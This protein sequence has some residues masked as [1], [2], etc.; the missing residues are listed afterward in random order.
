[1][2]MSDEARKARNEYLREWRKANAEKVK[3]HQQQY[4]ERK[5]AAESQTD[6]SAASR[7]E[8]QKT[9][10]Q[11]RLRGETIDLS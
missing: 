9:A 5:A 4:W 3:K 8:K 11:G 1:M 2:K 7:Q 6:A 10:E